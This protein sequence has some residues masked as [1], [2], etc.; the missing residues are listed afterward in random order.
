LGLV[1]RF[2][3]ESPLGLFCLSLKTNACG[4][5]A[6][7]SHEHAGHGH[8]TNSP[9]AQVECSERFPQLFE[10]RQQIFELD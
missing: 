1:I 5:E 6:S 3:P 7:P 10:Q 8:L 2:A 9:Y 4:Q